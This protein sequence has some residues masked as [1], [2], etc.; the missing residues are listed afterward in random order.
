[1]EI[2]VQTES[3][4]LPIRLCIER[5]EREG[6]AEENTRANNEK[7]SLEVKLRWREEK[8]TEFVDKF[9]GHWNTKVDA[10]GGKDR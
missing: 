9:K 7:T 4:H 5:D 2:K 10:H 6:K 8:A 3:D 1:M